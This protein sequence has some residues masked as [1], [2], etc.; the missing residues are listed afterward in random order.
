M[1]TVR[2]IFAVICIML[3]SVLSTSCSLVSTDP[4][5]LIKSPS[6]TGE[7]ADVLKAFSKYAGSD[8]SLVFPI[9]GDYTSA[10]VMNDIDADGQNEAFVFYKLKKEN[11]ILHVNLLKKEKNKWKSVAD[12]STSGTDIDK[13]IFSNLTGT[14]KKSL[15]IGLINSVDSSHTVEVLAYNN[16]YIEC[17]MQN[18]Y[19]D[20]ACSEMDND[21]REEIV[22]LCDEYNDNLAVKRIAI[23][24]NFNS[25]NTLVRDE[26]YSTEIDKNASDYH[27]SGAGSVEYA[28]ASVSGSE[29]TD[30]KSVE[31]RTANALYFDAL[32]NEEYITEIIYFNESTKSLVAPMYDIKTGSNNLTLRKYGKISKDINGDG[33]IEIPNDFALAGSRM[34]ETAYYVTQWMKLYSDNSF[35]DVMTVYT[36]NEN[37]FSMTFPNSWIDDNN[38]TVTHYN[39]TV[40]FS[41]W[42]ISANRKGVDLL[43]IR[44]VSQQS[45]DTSSITSSQYIR[46]GTKYGKIYL[47]RILETENKYSISEEQLVNGFKLK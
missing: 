31:V 2:R 4:E 14:Q 28:A 7:L 22:V 8:Y 26:L 15:I 3:I 42:D 25:D 32:K 39:N 1:K 19:V 16:G 41:L 45:W 11:Y 33:S 18:A 5:T 17:H 23:M 44:M 24:C 30:S 40:T 34:D 43:E 47:A 27:Y 46:L 12:Y 9:S 13:V 36:D 10:Y 20:F 35:M 6:P 29:V 38:I 37:K 21:G